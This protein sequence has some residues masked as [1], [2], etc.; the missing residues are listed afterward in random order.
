M[1][2]LENARCYVVQPYVA[3]RSGV[4]A[5]IFFVQGLQNMF[6][7]VVGWSTQ[8]PAHHTPEVGLPPKSVR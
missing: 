3:H 4:V 8:A 1:G 5:T 7:V 2:L 6:A